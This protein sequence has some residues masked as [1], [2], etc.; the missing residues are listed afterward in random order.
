M[1][2]SYT[3]S[4]PGTDEYVERVEND[5]HIHAGTFG[6]KRVVLYDANG[7]EIASGSNFGSQIVTGTKTVAAAGTAVRIT[8]VAT[9]IK[10][11][12]VSADFLAGIPVVIGDSAVVGN[13]TGLKGVILMPGN[14]PV[15]LQINDL[16]L[17]WVDAQTNGGKLAYAYLT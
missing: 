17:L 15:F 3:G 1:S 11:I 16:S 5:E 8:A 12:W 9:S 13:A 10:G 2:Q 4:P 7:V 14:P 6:A